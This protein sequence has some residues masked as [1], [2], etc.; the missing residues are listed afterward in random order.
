MKSEF[1]Q[2]AIR[3]EACGRL[4]VCKRILKTSENKGLCVDGEGTKELVKDEH[5][6]K[7]VRTQMGRLRLDYNKRLQR[8]RLHTV[9]FIDP[10]NTIPGQSRIESVETRPPHK[11]EQSQVPETFVCSNQGEESGTQTN[12][13]I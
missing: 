13:K 2:E 8:H 3:N 10:K 11:E 1:A 6:D 5:D 9:S 12:Q 7:F 4:I